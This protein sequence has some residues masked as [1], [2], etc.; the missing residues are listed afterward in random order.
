MLCWKGA[1]VR[2][3]KWSKVLSDIM[4]LPL[5][6]PFCQYIISQ[7]YPFSLIFLTTLGG[8][9]KNKRSKR[10]KPG[11]RHICKLAVS[12]LQVLPCLT[13]TILLWQLSTQFMY[14]GSASDI[15]FLGCLYDSWFIWQCLSLSTDKGNTAECKYIWPFKTLNRKQK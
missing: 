1:M 3:E 4:W 2:K 12:F 7:I 10:R 11:F 13:E 14:N 5:S 6:Y 15:V 8:Q 9:L